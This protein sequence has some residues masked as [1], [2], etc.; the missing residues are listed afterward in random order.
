MSNQ[1]TAMEV[2][3]GALVLLSLGLLIAF[4]VIL[5]DFGFKE[6]VKLQIDYA[7]IGGLKPGASVKQAGIEIGKVRQI[8]YKGGVI[9]PKT[10]QPVWAR[11]TI[12]VDPKYLAAIR[13]NSGFYIT[14][15]GVLGEKFMSIE[16]L[17][18]SGEAVA[19]DHVFRGVDPMRIEQMVSKVSRS[20]DA[21]ERLLNNSEVPIGDLVRHV[22]QLAVNIDALIVENRP[23]IKALLGSTGGLMERADGLLLRA[24]A[25][26]QKADTALQHADTFIVTAQETLTE[27]RPRVRS[28]LSQVDAAAASA[29]E[30]LRLANQTMRRVDAFVTKADTQLQPVITDVRAALEQ[31]RQLTTRALQTIE[32]I[33]PT[34]FN[35][36]TEA[37][38]ATADVRTITGATAEMVTYIQSGQGSLGAFLRDEEI[39]DNVREMLREL[40]RR[41]W[42]IIWKE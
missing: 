2:K 4:I 26:T 9:D 34:V 39:I 37:E 1:G 38:A 40:K 18:L 13:P 23:Q 27:S 10:Q 41:P 28:I 3:V 33:E 15:E 30:T 7:D 16:T 42:K 20:L 19:P 32:R 22:D 11:V 29:Q 6:G 25:A 36:L 5:G 24:D 35:I 21:L 17:D 12:E 14:T 31:V 8:E